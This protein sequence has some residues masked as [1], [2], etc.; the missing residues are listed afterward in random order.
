MYDSAVSSIKTMTKQN[1]R[2]NF[3]SNFKS[4][5]AIEVIRENPIM[6]ELENSIFKRYF[7]EGG[8]R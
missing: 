3:D 8:K 6:A 4:K 2:L 1:R 5:L 7:F